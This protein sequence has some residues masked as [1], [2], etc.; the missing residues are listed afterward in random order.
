MIDPVKITDPTVGE[1]TQSEALL[2]GNSHQSKFDVVLLSVRRLLKRGA[3]AN[4]TNLINRL[5]PADIARVIM[6]LDSPQERQTIF[7]LV[8]GIP[9][10]GQVVSELSEEMIPQVLEDRNAAEITWMLRF[11]PADDV[12]YILGV[13]PD[14][15]AQEILPLMKVEE[16]QEVVNLMAY[17]KGTAGSIMTTE[18]LALPEGTTAQESNQRL[19]QATKAETVFYIYVT[20]PN[21]K[22]TG[23]VSLRE[24]LVVAPTTP[25]KNMLTREVLSVTV[26]T[27]QEEVAR[28]VAT[29]NL[30]AIPVVGDDGRLVGII[31]V[32]DVVDVIREEDTKD[33][34]KMAGAAEEDAEMHRS[35]LQAVG[36]R[37]PWLFTNL[38]GSLV[39]GFI[40][41]WFRFTIQEVVIIVTFIPVIAAMSGNLGLQ[42][43]TLIIRG[44]ATGRVDLSDIWKVVSRELRIGLVLGL[45]CGTLLLMVG[46][47]WQG[48]GIFGVVVGGAL[49]M[50]FL[51]SASMASVTPL[52]LKKFKVDPAVAA[53][54]FITTAMDIIGVTIYLGLATMMLG[55]FR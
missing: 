34:L 43:S 31:T 49:L 28:Q 36:L 9:E 39:S 15:R 27:D 18:F 38:V 7:E 6:H 25:L 13:L 14:E 35:S 20:D 54:P 5:H 52:L 11:V 40:L 46:W 29:Y 4:L 55:H 10:Q 23:V 3:I 51:I 22:L 1:E 41:W 8:K 24:L 16:S 42:S 12:A 2:M 26:D 33:M 19:Q 32:D 53:G 21:E 30:L 37:L 44:L 47:G 50:T 45:I 17:P 48:S